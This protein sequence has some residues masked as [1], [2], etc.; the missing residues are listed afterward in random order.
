MKRMQRV[1]VF[2]VIFSIAALAF[3]F[4]AMTDQAEAKVVTTKNGTKLYC[5]SSGGGNYEVYDIENA[6]KDLIIP[7]T[8]DGKHKITSFH[9]PAFPTK[10]VEH[11]HLPSGIKNLDDMDDGE[12]Y[13]YNKFSGFPN[14]KKVSFDTRNRYYS[15]KDG[16]VYSKQGKKKELVAVAPGV[17]RVTI[18]SEVASIQPGAL[19]DLTK[20]ED[21][22]VEKGNKIFKSIKGALY[23]KD[24][25]KLLYYPVAK[26]DEVFRVPNGV[27]TILQMACYDQKYMKKT[28]M[29]SSVREIGNWAFAGC[30]RL[31]KVSLNK[32]LKILKYRAF[33]NTHW[34]DLSLPNGIEEVEIGS[35]PVKKLDIPAGCKKVEL[36]ED[37]HGEQCGIRAKTLIVR[38]LSLDMILLDRECWYDVEGDAEYFHES[39][40]KGKTIYAYKD[41]KAYKQLAP[42]AKAYHIK[43][44]LLKK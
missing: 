37:H 8:V 1:F 18:E 11:I 6:K 20:L 32:G 33:D 26:K 31:K 10:E 36:D 35:L 22:S 25:K 19:S 21:I 17:S 38:S 3:S 30:A 14:L 40:Y 41:S 13:P 4:S 42:V 12:G 9:C 34:L 43:L 44:K 15:A 5:R 16:K 7:E 23:T 39:A 2:S 24:G 28:V 27:K 29:S